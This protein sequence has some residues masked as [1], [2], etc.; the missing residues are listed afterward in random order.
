MTQED[1]I[2]RLNGL[3]AEELEA[4]LRYFHLSMTVRGM[5][6]LL[7]KD[8]LLEN[9]QETIDHARAVAE[10]IL[11][12]GGVP[13]LDIKLE[14]PAEKT[15]AQEALR[16]AVTVERAAL[17]AYRELLETAEAQGDLIVEEFAR[18][19]VAIESEHVAEL[20]LLLEE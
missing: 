20:E 18:A 7:V 3:L 2:E 10:K 11:Q 6:R 5:D 17:E 1:S 8:V 16:T 12:L 19:Q 9:M 14:L 4:G 15:S 13:K